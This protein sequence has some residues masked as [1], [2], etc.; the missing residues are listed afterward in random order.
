M[1]KGWTF[2]TCTR[3]DAK[4]LSDPLAGRCSECKGWRP[5]FYVNPCLCKECGVEVERQSIEAD[6][7]EREYRREWGIE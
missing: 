5:L 7:V 2:P 3:E 6:R 1:N 4:H